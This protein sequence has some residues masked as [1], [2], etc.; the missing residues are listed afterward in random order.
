MNEDFFIINGYPLD[1]QQI[2]AIINAGKYSLIVAGAGSGK[3]LTMIGKIKY[4]LEVKK[5]NQKK[6]YVFLLLM[7]LLKV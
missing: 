6:Y 7:N 1:N 4:L 3:T 2:K 5:L